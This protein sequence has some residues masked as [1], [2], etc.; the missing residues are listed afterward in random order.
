MK[1]RTNGGGDIVKVIDFVPTWKL[2]FVKKKRSFLEF[3]K[4]Q[5]VF[6]GNNNYTQY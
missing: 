4:T 1:A 5:S 2:K 6:S 3:F